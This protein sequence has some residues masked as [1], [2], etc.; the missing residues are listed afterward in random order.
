[1][2][3]FLEELKSRNETL[4]YFSAALFVMSVI[5]YLLTK[6]T[7]IQVSGISAWFKP[8][9]FAISISIYCSTMAW[10]CYEL[11]DFNIKLFNWA[12]I[13]L[14]SFEIVYINIQAARAKES[15][16]NQTTLFYRAM[17]GGM[18]IAAIAITIYAAYVGILFFQSNF[19]NLPVYYVWAIRLS[20]FIFI[21]FSF[22]GLLMGGRGTHTIGTR[23]QTTFLPLM[24]WNMTEGDLRVAHFIGMHG[25]QVI[26]LL[27]FYILKNTNAVFAVSGS[28]FLFAVFVLIQALKSKPFIKVKQDQYEITG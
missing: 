18:A 5:F 4:F 9:K 17:F 22:E 1:M 13:F 27:S 21:I 19:S 12:N 14:F 3:H 6:I 28:Y 11:P 10:F 7:S 26:P 2:L 25:L 24:K 16:F 15:H 20:I 8:F 23:V